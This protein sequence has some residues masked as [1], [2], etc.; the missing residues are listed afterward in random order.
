MG[1]RFQ[2][3]VRLFPGLRLNFSRSGISASVGHKGGWLT[4][5]RRTR[6]TVGI[7][8][9]GLFY[10][11]TLRRGGGYGLAILIVAAILAVVILSN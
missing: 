4:F 5:G 6:A 9:S 2:K 11:T 3:R 7:P 8:G 1:L 10:T